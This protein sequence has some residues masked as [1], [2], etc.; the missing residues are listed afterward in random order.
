MNAYDRKV[1]AVVYEALNAISATPGGGSASTTVPALAA[2]ANRAGGV[3][4][5]A[6]LAISELRFGDQGGTAMAYAEDA[7]R[8]AGVRDG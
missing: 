1:L 3:I 2:Y 7:A 6:M 8:A 4:W 5:P